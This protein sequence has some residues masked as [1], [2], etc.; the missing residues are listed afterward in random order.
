MR[1]LIIKFLLLFGLSL[2]MA[3]CSTGDRPLRDEEREAIEM[4]NYQKW[5]EAQTRMLT[6]GYGKKKKDGD[7]IWHTK[8][9][10]YK[11]K[12]LNRKQ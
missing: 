7:V 1:N 11:L 3:S 5:E 4:R 12:I 6:D 9:K 8:V 2:L 10:K